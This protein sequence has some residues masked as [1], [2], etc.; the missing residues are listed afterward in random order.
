MRVQ[1]CCQAGFSLTGRHDRRTK[2][3]QRSL[4]SALR[5]FGL[6]LA[7]FCSLSL[8]AADTDYKQV[9]VIPTNQTILVRLALT[10][11]TGKVRVKEESP[12]GSGVPIAPTRTPSARDIIWSGRSAT[13]APRPTAPPRFHK[14]TSP[15][16]SP[17]PRSSTMRTSGIFCGRLWKLRV[18]IHRS[19]E[20]RLRANEVSTRRAGALRSSSYA[21]ATNCRSTYGRIPPCW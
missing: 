13:T 19:A 12:D 21:F 6:L 8:F 14:S 3:F 11:V 18:P 15:A 20:L 4:E 2:V 9:L 16:P 5:R 1:P 10:D 7:L 17:W